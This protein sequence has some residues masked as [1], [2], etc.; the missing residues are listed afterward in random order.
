MRRNAAHP[1]ASL[2]LRRDM[3]LYK[4]FPPGRIEVLRNRRIRFTQ[5][6]DFNDPFEFKPVI[7]EIASDDNVRAYVEKNFDK[8]IYEELAKYGAIVPAFPKELFPGFIA[9]QKKNLPDL[10]KALSPQVI[11]AIRPK[12]A[13]LLNRHVGVLCLS[14]VRDSLLMWGHYTSNHC[15]FVVGFDTDSPFF[16]TRRTESDEFGFLRK[17]KYSQHRPHVTL[18]NS[19]SVIWFEQKSHEWAYEKEWRI[20]RVLHDATLVIQRKPFSI[21]LFEFPAAAVR[22]IIIGTR[23]STALRDEI[24]SLRSNFPHPVSFTANEHSADY[25]VTIDQSN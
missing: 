19:D 12:L 16:S 3:I 7:G 1:A 8:M 20:L 25:A 14:E 5:P 13:E 18:A 15:G 11:D 2:D 9:A 4:Y 22:E 10:F 24:K 17:V 23:A 21:H 6:A